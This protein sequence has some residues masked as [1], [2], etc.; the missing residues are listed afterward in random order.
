M[1][2]LHGFFKESVREADKS[3]VET[4]FGHGALAQNH[5]VYKPGDAPVRYV[6]QMGCE[7]DKTYDLPGNC[8]VCNMKLVEA[9]GIKT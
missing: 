5:Q 2:F 3:A 6:C 9:E 4:F 8:P 7:G 1:K